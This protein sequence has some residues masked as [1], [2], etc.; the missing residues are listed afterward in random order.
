MV[1]APNAFEGNWISD[2][3]AELVDKIIARQSAEFLDSI[4]NGKRP[5]WIK[6]FYG[7]AVDLPD[8][9]VLE[10][11]RSRADTCSRA[12]V[13][14]PTC[15]RLYLQTEFGKNEYVCYIIEPK[16]ESSGAATPTEE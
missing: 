2:V 5:T 7:K 10:D 4:K 12:T 11:I 13:H 6:R 8:A 16:A 15:Q 14:C 3:D 9:D 1:E